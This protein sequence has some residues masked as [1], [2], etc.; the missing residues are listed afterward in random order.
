MRVYNNVP[1]GSIGHYRIMREV[2]AARSDRDLKPEE[3]FDFANCESA[4]ASLESGENEEVVWMRFCSTKSEWIAARRRT[5]RWSF[6][7]VVWGK[8]S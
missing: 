8:R 5:R 6:G 2:I 4:I 3:E 7:N 1:V